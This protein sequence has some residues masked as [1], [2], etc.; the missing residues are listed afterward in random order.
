MAAA[1]SGRAR[2][3]SPLARG[4]ATARLL[5]PFY[6]ANGLTLLRLVGAPGVVVLLL[7]EQALAALALFTAAALTDAMDG[8][9]ARRFNGASP[10]GRLLD[11]LA[12]KLLVGSVALALAALGAVPAWLAALAIGRDAALGAGALVVRR[13]AAFRIEPLVIGKACTLAQLLYLG[14]AIAERG[15]L[16]VA[17]PIAVVLLPIATLLTLLSAVAYLGSGIG[18]WHAGAAARR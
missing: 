16:A 14:A 4:V 1:T 8:F 18:R 12:D 13:R 10:L 3:R 5:A 15:G 6:V 7:S 9:V 11:P 17:G 2:A